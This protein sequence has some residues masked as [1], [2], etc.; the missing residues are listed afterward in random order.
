MD[1]DRVESIKKAVRG[2]RQETARNEDLKARSREADLER[3]K[4]VLE[5]SGVRKLLQEIV[6]DGAIR[7]SNEPI[8]EEVYTDNKYTSSGGPQSHLTE[9]NII[10]PYAPAEIVSTDTTISLQY[11][12]HTRIERSDSDRPTEVNFH[13]EIRFEVVDG[14]VTLVNGGVALTGQNLEEAIIIALKNPLEVRR[15][16]GIIRPLRRIKRK[17]D[18]KRPWWQ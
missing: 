10:S 2:H 4:Q 15:S 16:Y 14:I 18:G 1:E 6:A 13:D 17:G 12:H 9:T 7:L 11:N 5:R 3:Q 8:V